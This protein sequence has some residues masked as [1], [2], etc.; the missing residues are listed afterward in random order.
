MKTN[1]PRGGS[2]EWDLSKFDDY[3]LEYEI[4]MCRQNLY[5]VWLPKHNCGLKGMMNWT[6]GERGISEE[7]LRIAQEVWQSRLKR[8]EDE[9]FERKVLV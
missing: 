2:D 4:E 8:A 5:G 3:T 6:P 7:R 1:Y 9:L